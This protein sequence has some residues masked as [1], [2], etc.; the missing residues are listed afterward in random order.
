MAVLSYTIFNILHTFLCICQILPNSV[1]AEAVGK[2]SAAILKAVVSKIKSRPPCLEQQVGPQERLC[3]AIV[4]DCCS[5]MAKFIDSH[6]AAIEWITLHSDLVLQLGEVYRHIVESASGVKPEYPYSHACG[7][8]K[9]YFDW[10]NN[11]C[12]TLGEY[13]SKIHSGAFS[14]SDLLRYQICHS[15]CSNMANMFCA[16]DLVVPMAELTRLEGCYEELF[17]Q[18]NFHLIKHN[19]EGKWCTLPQIL[20][21]Y[22]VH[23]PSEF[24]RDLILPDENADLLVPS[25]ENNISQSPD[26]SMVQAR[27]S[28]TFRALQLLVLQLYEYYIEPIQDHMKTLVLFHLSHNEV[29]KSYVLLQLDIES[30]K[31]VSAIAY[32]LCHIFIF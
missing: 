8:V 11:I 32:I 2:S 30:C 21:E 24:L 7:Y 15:Y 9:N 14:Y 23:F 26:E 25:N 17:K 18:V 3:W 29:F 13:Y 22:G 6:L 12:M 5:Q 1:A 16:G 19:R 27:Q 20:Q 10:V 31:K 4:S 28:L